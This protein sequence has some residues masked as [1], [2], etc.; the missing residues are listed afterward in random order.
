MVEVLQGVFSRPLQQAIFDH[1]NFGKASVSGHSTHTTMVIK[2]SMG[3]LAA[4]VYPDADE[5]KLSSTSV[6][7]ISNALQ[8]PEHF[9]VCCDLMNM[10][11]VVDDQTYVADPIEAQN[12][13]RSAIDSAVVH[14]RRPSSPDEPVVG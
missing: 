9:R 7:I 13:A 8:R 4:L 6:S 11:F 3:L 10:L 1:C 5:G 2:Y 12:I 14:P